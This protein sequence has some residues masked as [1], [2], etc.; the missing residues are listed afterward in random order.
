MKNTLLW[1]LME[2]AVDVN[3][4]DIYYIYDKSKYKDL[5]KELS[6]YPDLMEEENINNNKIITEAFSK[7][8]DQSILY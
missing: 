4:S 1:K 8:E 2:E 3:Y 7:G 6:Y 5:E